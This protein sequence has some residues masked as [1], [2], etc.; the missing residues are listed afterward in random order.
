MGPAASVA[1]RLAGRSRLSTGGRFLEDPWR[2]Y[3]SNLFHFD[4]LEAASLF[5]TEVASGLD[6]MAPVRRLDG[7]WDEGSSAASGRRSQCWLRA[8]PP[9]TPPVTRTDARSGWCR[10]SPPNCCDS[11]VPGTSAGSDDAVR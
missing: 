8:S 7:L 4:P 11:A 9:T 3:R 5:R 6:V 1:G 10:L 2:A